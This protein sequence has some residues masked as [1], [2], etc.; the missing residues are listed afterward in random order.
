VTPNIPLA[1]LK[2]Q[3]SQPEVSKQIIIP[4][5]RSCDPR[6]D[7][8]EKFI[9]SDLD[10]RIDDFNMQQ[11]VNNSQMNKAEQM[12]ELETKL[13]TEQ[14]KASDGDNDIMI[15]DD[16]HENE[17]LRALQKRISELEQINQQL[18]DY[19]ANLIL[20]TE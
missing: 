7:D 8:D 11:E 4:P 6:L 20:D 5:R 17:Q 10:R 16:D 19:A 9:I 14:S 2:R 1:T 3:Q 18:Y 13:V 12:K 15:I